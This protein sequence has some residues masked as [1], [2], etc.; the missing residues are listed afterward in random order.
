MKMRRKIECYKA[1]RLLTVLVLAALFLALPQGR[2]WADSIDLDRACSLTVLPAGTTSDYY[3]DLTQNTDAVVDLYKV[4]DAVPVPGYDTFSLS[5]RSGFGQLSIPELPTNA[6]WQNLAMQAFQAVQ[7]GAGAQPVQPTVRGAAMKTAIDLSGE[8]AGPGLYL[9]IARSGSVTAAADYTKTIQ[10]D[11][12]TDTLVTVVNSPIYEYQYEPQ[13]I[14]VPTK[15]A[16]D[17]LDD[18]G[19]VIGSEINTANP[20]DWIYNPTIAMKPERESRMG[21]LEIV[22]TLQGFVGTE[23][24]AFVFSIEAEWP[25]PASPNGKA[26]YSNTRTMFFSTDGTQRL[27]IEKK[28]PIGVEVTVKEEYSGTQY[29]LNFTDQEQMVTISAEEIVQAAFTNVFDR[30]IIEGIGIENHFEHDGST[31]RWV[32]RRTAA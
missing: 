12:G 26:F 3:E 25:D 15:D 10:T 9:V 19:T 27:K 1:V 28:I 30:K 17:V 23:P 24:V 22:K 32:E 8:S 11:E 5:L 16:V 18:E 31:W 20:G 4:A 6:D 29:R 2:A 7:G 13:L 21:D 14:A